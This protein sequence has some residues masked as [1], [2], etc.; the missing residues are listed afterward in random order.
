[1]SWKSE[2]VGPEGKQV[3]TWSEGDEIDFEDMHELP[4]VATQ[5]EDR[6]RTGVE[7]PGFVEDCPK[8]FGTGVWKHMSRHGRSCFKC[9]GTGKLHFKTS[10]AQR[11]KGRKSAAKAK[12]RKAEEVKGDWEQWLKDRP[13]IHDWL[14]TGVL[15]G[16]QFAMSLSQGGLKYGHLTEGQENAA[17]KAVAAMDDGRDGFETWCADHDG[18]LEWLKAEVEKGNEF[19]GSLMAYGLRKGLLTD[20]QLN[21]VL[22]NLESPKQD[23]K[24]SELDLTP[25]LKGYY[26]VPDGDTRLKVAIRRPG[27]NSRWHGWTFVDDGAAY[28]SRKTYGKQGPGELY[29]GGIQSALQ[30]IMEDPKGAMIAYGK[31]TGTCGVCGRILEDEDSVAAGIG[32]VCAAKF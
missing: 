29:K 22:N 11:A 7:I 8:C 24:A 26:A 17:L 5:A 27:K 32:P 20:G 15:A 18:V 1:M 25:L 30:A 21:A 6:Q 19:A 3:R 23:G 13:A 4:D 28:G 12:V 2:M 14:K 9:K 16:N 31:L 10:P